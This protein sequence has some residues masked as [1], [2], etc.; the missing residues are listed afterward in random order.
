MYDWQNDFFGAIRDA[1]LAQRRIAE[2]ALEQVDDTDFTRTAGPGDNSIAAIAKHVG[3]NLRSRWTQPFETDGEK[4][5][6]DRDREFE[7]ESDT[8][9]DVMGVWNAGWSALEQ[10]LLA[11]R[12]ADMERTLYIRGEANTL[13]GALHRS[14]A[15]TAQHVGQIILLAKQ[16]RGSD[17]RTL[18][19]PRG[20]S[21]EFLTKPPA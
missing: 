17:W 12:P 3:G 13:V 15:H 6:R 11:L 18:S 9:E 1:F 21:R 10:T 19:I 5:D 4:P 2:R 14:L 7:V 20:R 16:W 8:R